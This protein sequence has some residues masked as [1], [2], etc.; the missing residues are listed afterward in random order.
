VPEEL[1]V[2][3]A[4]LAARQKFPNGHNLN[5]EYLEAYFEPTAHFDSWHYLMQLQQ[6]RALTT[7]VEWFRSLQP[8]C[9]GTLYW[10]FND[11]WPTMS[12]AAVDGY[13]RLKP[14]WYATRR[15]YAPRLL[16]IQ[17]AQ[18]VLNV[19]V[20]NDSSE[21]WQGNLILSRITFE[22]I[23]KA[24]YQL[25]VYLSP[26]S[27]VRIEIDEPVARAENSSSEMIMAQLGDQRTFWFFDVDKNL[28]YPEPSYEIE[29]ID[30]THTTTHYQLT[31]H[32]LL[33]DVIIAVDRLDSDA[34]I[35]D[36]LLTILPGETT[37]FQ[38]HSKVAISA[39]Q[40]STPPVFQSVNNFGRRQ[41]VD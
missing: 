37:T 8:E 27:S 4:G 33:R 16:T 1:Q 3:S 9:M 38:I 11:C 39:A 31:A 28:D 2:H 12:F 6:A 40:L 5:A 34:F 30:K 14:L 7:A 17:P 21:V 29:L 32:T 13:G 24:C 35:S 22:G 15:F 20:C 19:H 41:I 36:Q 26:Y 23:Q 18:D 10:Q 25:P